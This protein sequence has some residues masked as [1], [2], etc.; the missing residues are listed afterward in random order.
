M[1]STI[2]SPALIT[3]DEASW[4]GEAEFGPEPTMANDETSCPAPVSRSRTSR[5]TSFSVRPSSLPLVIA[6]TTVSTARPAPRNSA[7]S[8]ADFTMRSLPI[9]CDASCVC[10]MEPWVRSAASMRIKKVDQRRSETATP[11]EAAPDRPPALTAAA[12]RANGSSVSPK[13]TEATWPPRIAGASPAMPAS[14]RGTIS[15]GAPFAGITNM[16]SRSSA[17]AA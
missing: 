3:R 4:C 17:G 2:A 1:S 14:S 6:I 16:V 10:V 5:A 11:R 15:V 7:A 12:T 9:T 13:V 8:S